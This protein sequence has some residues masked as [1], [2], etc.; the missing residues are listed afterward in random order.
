MTYRKICKQLALVLA[1]LLLTASAAAEGAAAFDEMPTL[2]PVEALTTGATATTQATFAPEVTLA[3]EATTDAGATLTP[4]VT[5]APIPDADIGDD[6]ILR[7]ELR[8]LEIGR[9]SC[10]ERV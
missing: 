2:P 8:S 6:G 4:E 10:R 7:V 5:F 1:T 3:P 9:A